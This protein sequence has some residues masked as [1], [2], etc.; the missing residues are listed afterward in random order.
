MKKFMLGMALAV[1]M[2]FVS[3]PK[4]DALPIYSQGP[5]DNG[6]APVYQLQFNGHGGLSWVFVGLQGC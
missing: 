1:A 3:V 6:W 2:L 4:A 5:C